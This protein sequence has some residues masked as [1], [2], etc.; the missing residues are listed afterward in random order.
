MNKWILTS[1]GV[2]L[3]GQ[4]GITRIDHHMEWADGI[5]IK[6]GCNLYAGMT[7]IT[8]IDDQYEAIISQLLGV[9]S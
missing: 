5:K 8:K 6:N 9:E 4:G 1:D 2:F 7:L 3:F